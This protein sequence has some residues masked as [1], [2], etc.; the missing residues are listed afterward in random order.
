MYSS[1]FETLHLLLSGKDVC[2]DFPSTDAL[3]R[4][5]PQLMV[6]GLLRRYHSWTLAYRQLRRAEL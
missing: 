2:V 3:I 6:Y 5:D 4:T 1:E